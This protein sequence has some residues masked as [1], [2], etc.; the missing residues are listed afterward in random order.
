MFRDT[1]HGKSCSYCDR[2]MNSRDVRL[3]ATRDHVVPV[4]K[5]GKVKLICCITCNGI[6]GDMLPEQWGAFMAAHPSWWLLTKYELRVIR[7]AELGLP[8]IRHARRA[9]AIKRVAVVVPPELIYR[10]S[11]P[12]TERND[13]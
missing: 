12:A 8:T 2:V 6:K 9:R 11:Q 13:Q 5:G 3:H 1:H 4:S 10:A 7:R